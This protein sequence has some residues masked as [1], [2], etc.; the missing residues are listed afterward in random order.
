LQGPASNL[1]ALSAGLRYHTH[2]ALVGFAYK[3]G[4]PAS[5]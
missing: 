3:F 5:Y 1:D 4:T 2:T